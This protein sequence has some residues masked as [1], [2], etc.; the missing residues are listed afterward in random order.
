MAAVGGTQVELGR[1]VETKLGLRPGREEW[2]VRD[3]VKTGLSQTMA[4]KTAKKSF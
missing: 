3:V 2:D 4:G 1:K